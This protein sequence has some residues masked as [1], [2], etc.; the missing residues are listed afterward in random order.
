MPASHG[1]QKQREKQKKKREAAKKKHATR[2]SIADRGLSWI[3]REAAKLPVGRCFISA[4]FADED[5]DR[6][7]LVSVL[8][9]R[10]APGGIVIPALALID[11]TCLGVKNAF[12]GEPFLAAEL[13]RFAASVG[14]AHEVGMMQ[15]DFLLAQSVVYHAIDYARRLGFEPHKDFPEPVFGPRPERLLETPLAN[16]ARPFYLAGP[17]DNVERVLAQLDRAV[18]PGNYDTLV[19]A[20]GSLGLLDDDDDED[21][22][23]AI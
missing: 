1:K 23:E 14:E 19:S 3:L 21:E 15:C 20:G 9:S 10:D 22:D 5:L 11:R 7:R 8:V 17:D 12:V 13:D 18:G 2:P 16:R 4:D 6:P